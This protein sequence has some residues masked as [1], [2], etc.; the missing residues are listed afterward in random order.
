MLTFS[1]MPL[2]VQD[3][4]FEEASEEAPAEPEIPFDLQDLLT[5]AFE[6]EAPPAPPE[7]LLDVAP[8]VYVVGQDE[9]TPAEVP[10][11]TVSRLRSRSGR[12]AVTRELVAIIET[13][14]DPYVPGSVERF[15]VPT[16]EEATGEIISFGR[17][18][19]GSRVFPSNAIR[20]NVEVYNDFMAFAK[21]KDTSNWCFWNVGI[22][23]N[24]SPVNKLASELKR[25]NKVLNI[26]I[27]D[28]RK[29]NYIEVLLIGIHLRYDHNFGMF[30]LHA[31][32]ICDVPKE[33]HSFASSKF[34][35]KFS[36]TQTNDWKI[37]NLEAA[38]TYLL[39]GII[40][41]DKLVACPAEA[42]KAVWDITMARARLMRT[43][44]RF[45]EW[46]DA[47]KKEKKDPEAQAA[48]RR[49]AQ[50]RAETAY[51]GEW[52]PAGFRVMT[53]L[54]LPMEDGRRRTGVLIEKA[55]ARKA[56]VPL[57]GP[58]Y[59][60]ATIA[61]TQESPERPADIPTLAKATP[62]RSRRPQAW[63]WQA[64]PYGRSPST[65]A[66]DD[67]S[68]LPA[69]LRRRLAACTPGPGRRPRAWAFPG[70]A[71]SNPSPA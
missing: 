46:R 43:G 38:T 31:H 48:R 57:K 30:D 62:P 52:I 58:T 33:T 60:S 55:P 51:K 70:G 27:S 21:D 59:P 7:M 53:K 67:L 37:R 5:I 44:G 6:P 47:R 35:K 18:L 61:V 26:A 40:E 12:K 23:N 39:W 41:A 54:T 22:P 14:D 49:K 68:G 1:E 45:A 56:L 9:E 8:R 66:S 28:I 29:I 19:R 4:L 15:F 42:V 20:S 17:P 16:D 25:F 65:A 63:W 3:L 10:E 13:F 71:R 69:P 11:K 64:W 2:D 32:I 24:K 34:F 36:K 50:N